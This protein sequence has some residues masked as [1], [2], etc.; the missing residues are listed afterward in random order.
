MLLSF[1]KLKR[2]S[3]VCD[4]V[5][6]PTGHIAHQLPSDERSRYHIRIARAKNVLH[7]T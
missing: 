7:I 5:L 2:E 3:N 1:K 6:Y 4:I